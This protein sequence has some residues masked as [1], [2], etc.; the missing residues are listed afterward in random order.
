MFVLHTTWCFPCIIPTSTRHP[1]LSIQGRTAGQLCAGFDAIYATCHRGYGGREHSI[2]KIVA[3][4]AY[5]Y[6]YYIYNINIIIYINIYIYYRYVL[7][8]L[9]LWWLLNYFIH[10]WQLSAAKLDGTIWWEDAKGILASGEPVGVSKV[11]DVTHTSAQQLT[12]KSWNHHNGYHQLWGLGYTT[13][14]DSCRSR[15]SKH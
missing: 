3:W 9:G 4:Y 5:I 6:N 14:E 1:K 12:I 8:L 13:F 7:S 11:V 10:A 15:R 2:Q